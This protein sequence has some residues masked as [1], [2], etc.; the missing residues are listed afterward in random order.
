MK[1]CATN[2]CHRKG[3]LVLITGAHRILSKPKPS[4]KATVSRCPY[5][6]Q[7]NP[8]DLLITRSEN[9]LQTSFPNLSLLI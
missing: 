8:E 9:E 7:Q 2:P 6:I 5:S 1:N 3:N 4:A